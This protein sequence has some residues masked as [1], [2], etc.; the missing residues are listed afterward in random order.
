MAGFGGVAEY[1]ITV[2]WDK[3]YLTLVRT[4]LERRRNFALYGG[5]RFGSNID[6]TISELMGF[7]HIVL[8]CGAG[9]P[10][11]PEDVPNIMARGCKMASEFLMALQS[12]G[13]ASPSAIA[14]LQLR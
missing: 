5:V 12:T 4:L 1:G 9:K 6:Y 8:A 11:L 3:I 13:A 7:D 10:N 2:R 14:N